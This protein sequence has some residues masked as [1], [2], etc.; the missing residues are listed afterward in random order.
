MRYFDSIL[1]F[2]RTPDAHSANKGTS[3]AVD[4]P[5]A[6]EAEGNSI[7]RPIR[8]RSGGTT[9]Q[10]N[11]S[12]HAHAPAVAPRIAAPEVACN[13]AAALAERHIASPSPRARDRHGRQRS[14][15]HQAYRS[16]HHAHRTETQT[17][18]GQTRQKATP[19]RRIMKRAAGSK[20]HMASGKRQAAGVVEQ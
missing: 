17:E 11:P 13:S 4:T 2:P 7:A 16:T 6:S 8:N 10:P 9:H 5:R 18:K 12:H 15:H 20:R 3:L 1:Y 14:S 19:S